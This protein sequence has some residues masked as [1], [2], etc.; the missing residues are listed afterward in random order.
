VSSLHVREERREGG[1]CTTRFMPSLRE[2]MRAASA[3]EYSAHNSLN[4]TG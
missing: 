3:T 1:E 4:A 2:V